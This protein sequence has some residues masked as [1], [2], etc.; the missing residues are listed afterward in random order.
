M[1]K[2]KYIIFIIIVLLNV[3][4]TKKN[5]IIS[6]IEEKDLELQVFEAYKEGLRSLEEGDVLFAAKKFNEAEILFPQSEWAPRSSLMAAY[7][8][9]SQEYYI[10]SIAEL[11]RFIKIYP[12]NKNLDYA[13]YMLGIV[14]Y[15]Q[16]VDEKK[17]L[18]SINNAKNTFKFVI[19]NFPNTD[20]ALDAKFKLGMVNNILASKEM[21]VANY[22]FDKKKWIAALN[23][24]KIV[25]N[26]Y[27]TTIYVEEALHRMVEIN[28]H[29]GLQ[30]EAKKY[31]QLLGYNYQSSEWYERSYSIFNESYEKNKKIKTKKN[32]IIL[33]KFK[34]LFD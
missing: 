34:S 7:S 1:T 2:V 11:K 9:Y 20:Y 10:D 23:R 21:Y 32:N 18:K 22:Y 26:K 19:K 28:Y 5:E 29:L 24:F 31:A 15:E 8:Y 25:I 27:E 30:S 12:K 4:C 16:I 17:D 13:Y 6:K 33:R 14:Y 3:S